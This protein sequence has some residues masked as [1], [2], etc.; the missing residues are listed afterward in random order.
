[1]EATVM[2][3]SVQGQQV[4][5]NVTHRR[6]DHHFGHKVFYVFWILLLRYIYDP[7]FYKFDHNSNSVRL[8]NMYIILIKYFWPKSEL[9]LFPGNPIPMLFLGD[10]LLTLDQP[11]AQQCVPFAGG[12]QLVPLAF[13]MIQKATERVQE[14]GEQTGRGP[15]EHLGMGHRHDAHRRRS[16]FERGNREQGK[17]RGRDVV[18]LGIND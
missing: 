4:I 13:Q 2:E 8:S 12:G 6:I 3:L 15:A 18:H 9:A 10:F 11:H 7:F 1:M 14:K 5:W 16:E 17:G